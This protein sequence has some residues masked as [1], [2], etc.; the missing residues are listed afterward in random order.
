MDSGYSFDAE[1]GEIDNITRRL[2]VG[3]DSGV[4]RSVMDVGWS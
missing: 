3:P 4:L 2:L 1:V